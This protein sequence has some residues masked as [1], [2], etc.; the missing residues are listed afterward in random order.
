LNITL[1]RTYGPTA[2]IGRLTAGPVVFYS[3]ELPWVY[4]EADVSCVPEGGYELVPYESPAHGPTWC[5]KNES[6]GVYAFKPASQPQLVGYS[7]RTYCEIHSANW[8]EQLQGCIAIGKN[9]YPMLNPATGKVE[10]AVEDS[11]DAVSQ[12]LA[13]LGPMSFGHTLTVSAVIPE[14]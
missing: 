13:I 14:N 9:S 4:D 7:V 5:L 11:V 12:L 6:I 10:V 3:L 2:T 8:A 1:V